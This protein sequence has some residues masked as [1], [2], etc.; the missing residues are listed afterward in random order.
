[1]LILDN[2]IL[3]VFWIIINVNDEI[4]IKIYEFKSGDNENKCVLII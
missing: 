2:S 4:N 3:N 1:M